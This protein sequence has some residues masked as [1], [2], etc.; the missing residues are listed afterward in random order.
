MWSNKKKFKNLLTN[1]LMRK[2]KFNN[3]V[4]SN[5]ARDGLKPLP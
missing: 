4:E 2:I 5:K 1:T 3:V